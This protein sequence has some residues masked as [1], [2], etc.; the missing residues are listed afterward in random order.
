MLKFKNDELLI[1]IADVNNRNQQRLLDQD[2][3][4]QKIEY[5]KEN[6]EQKFL[7]ISRHVTPNI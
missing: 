3:F 6:F 4:L 7:T 2:N 5:L 1:S